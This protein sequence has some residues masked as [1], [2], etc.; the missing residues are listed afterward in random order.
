MSEVKLRRGQSVEPALQRLR[1]LVDREGTI[2]K[3]R[4]KRFFEKPSRK[5]YRTSRRAKYN[6]R[7]R[8]KEDHY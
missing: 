4:E 5:K 7:M 3:I 6:Q 1:K 8:S 2:K